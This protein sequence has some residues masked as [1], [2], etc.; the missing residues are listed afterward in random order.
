LQKR[1]VL[2]DTPDTDYPTSYMIHLLLCFDKLY[3]AT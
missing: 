1:L 2:P 3:Q